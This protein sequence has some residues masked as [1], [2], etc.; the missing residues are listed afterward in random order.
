MLIRGLVVVAA[1]LT[2]GQGAIAGEKPT[3]L[4]RVSC[5][6]DRFYVARYSEVATETWA[7]NHGA[8]GAE[9]ESARKCFVGS[10]VQTGSLR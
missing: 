7:R 3:V 9:I 8:T 10:N 5:T 1:L 2:P 4:R 6:V